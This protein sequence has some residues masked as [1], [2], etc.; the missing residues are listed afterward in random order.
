MLKL[1]FSGP[2]L[3]LLLAVIQCIAAEGGSGIP[4]PTSHELGATCYDAGLPPSANPFTGASEE[5]AASWMQGWL[6]ASGAEHSTGVLPEG[7]PLDK[8]RAD[9]GE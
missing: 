4:I 2:L 9:N 6:E 7:H 5:M 1:L 8:W 3:I